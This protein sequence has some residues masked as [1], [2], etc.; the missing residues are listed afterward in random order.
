MVKKFN[1]VY[2]FKI[3]LKD[4]KPPIWRRIQVPETFTFW[5]LHFTIQDAMGWFNFHLHDFNIKDP[6]TN[7]SILIGKPQEDIFFKTKKELPGW[8]EKIA[9]RFYKE[10]ISAI[11]TYDFGD[12][13]EHDIEL[14]KILSKKE[15]IKYP[16]CLAGK[17]ACPPESCG[18]IPGYY[19]LLE[20]M[21][22]KCHED[23]ESMIDWLGGEFDPEEFNPDD[24]RFSIPRTPDQEF[25]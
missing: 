7:E 11:Y 1:N 17:L 13:W 5:D 3:T 23:Y 4:T 8:E 10:N 21:N 22:D 19:H 25:L 24:V 16:I 20:I 2:Q 15:D 9:D 6:I 12:N 18:G 14:E